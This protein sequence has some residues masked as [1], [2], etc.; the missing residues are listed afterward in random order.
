[1]CL[2][3]LVEVMIAF[4]AG[5]MSGPLEPPG[6]IRDHAQRTVW[7]VVAPLHRTSWLLRRQKI[8]SLPERRRPEIRGERSFYS[9]VAF[10]TENLTI[11]AETA[12]QNFTH[13]RPSSTKMEDEVN[14]PYNRN[15]VLFP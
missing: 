2:A 7:H 5:F 4:F 1:M 13:W 9:E 8:W 6:P 12:L 15:L 11:P 3:T 10:G 14:V